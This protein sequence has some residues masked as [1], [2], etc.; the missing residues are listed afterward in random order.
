MKTLWRLMTLRD[1]S[2]LILFKLEILPRNLYDNKSTTLRFKIMTYNNKHFVCGKALYVF[3]FITIRCLI[4]RLFFFIF[5]P[6]N[7]R[8][9]SLIYDNSYH[10]A[11][12]WSRFSFLLNENWLIQCSLYISTNTFRLGQS[13]LITSTLTLTFNVA[14]IVIPYL[15]DI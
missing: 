9:K 3:W 8:K 7:Q 11:R 15:Y 2:M 6:F 12:K 13:N 5:F 4:V 1:M 10:Y 14:T